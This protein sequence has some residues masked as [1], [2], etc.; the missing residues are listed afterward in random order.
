MSLSGI[1]EEAAE[2][3]RTRPVDPAEGSPPGAPAPGGSRELLT[4]ALPLVVS[5]GFM[6]GSRR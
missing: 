1:R 2:E 4:L 5:Q 3:V 6:T